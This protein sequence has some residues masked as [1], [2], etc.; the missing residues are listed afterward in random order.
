MQS[1]GSIGSLDRRRQGI[2][3]LLT[4]PYSPE[5]PNPEWSTSLSLGFTWIKGQQEI[6]T[7]TN[8]HHW[9][10]LCAFSTKKSLAQVK[11]VFGR[12]CHAELSRSERAAEYVWKDDT[13][14]D[15]TRFEFGAKPIRRNSA[16]D[17]ESVW[18]SAKSGSLDAIP[19]NVRVVNYRYKFI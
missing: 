12:E 8:Y 4:I 15:G 7:E 6:G 14:V 18:E 1:N 9:Q 11:A 10:V 5:Q 3:W 13:S 19:A 17:W 2:F 16:V